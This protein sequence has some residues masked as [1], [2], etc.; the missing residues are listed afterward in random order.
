[1]DHEDIDD[2]DVFIYRGGR[3]PRHVT[4]VLIDKSV[5]EIEDYAFEDCPKL[6]QVDT[7]NGLRKIGEQAFG[8]CKSLRCINLKSAIEIDQRAFYYCD[9]LESVEFGDKLEIIGTSAFGYCPLRHLK[10]PSI[11]TIGEG[12]FDCAKLIDI[13]FSEQLE[14]I[15]ARSFRYCKRLQRIVIPMKRNLFS[16]C[17]IFQRYNQFDECEQ[18]ATVDLVGGI[19][20]TIASL[21]MESWRTEMIAE[22]NSIN[23]VLPNTPVNKKSGAIQRWMEIVLDKMDHYKAQHCSYVW[24][25]TALLELALWK[26]KLGEIAE[27][28]EEGKPKKAKVVSESYRKDK[29]ITCGADMVIKNVLPFLQ[30]E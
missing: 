5:D 12:A 30:L 7:H 9:K 24:E 18:L 26:N 22:I 11:I 6:L 21:H 14:T 8:W 2:G 16:L 3:A 23:Q 28:A 19:L 13:E 25:G 27:Y 20:T 15:G 1:M 10:V 29:R 4:H 17:D